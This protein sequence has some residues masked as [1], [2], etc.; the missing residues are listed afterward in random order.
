TRKRDAVCGSYAGFIIKLQQRRG[1]SPTII[2][3]KISNAECVYFLRP[4]IADQRGIKIS[5]KSRIGE[6]LSIAISRVAAAGI[7]NVL[8]TNRQ[9]PVLI[10]VSKAVIG[11]YN[12]N[13]VRSQA[14]DL[15]YRSVIDRH[16]HVQLSRL[17]R[18]APEPIRDFNRIKPSIQRL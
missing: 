16:D 8:V 10:R 3:R 12:S 4:Q 9:R 15:K 18:E 14:C 6:S 13:I 5:G 17:A 1:R 2:H 7:K 11:L